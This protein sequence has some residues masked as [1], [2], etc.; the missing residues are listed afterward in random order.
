MVRSSSTSPTRTWPLREGAVRRDIGAPRRHRRP[1][2]DPSPVVIRTP[3]AAPAREHRVPRSVLLPQSKDE[4]LDDYRGADAFDAV[5]YPR[6][7]RDP[8]AGASSRGGPSRVLRGPVPP[9]AI[10]RPAAAG[11]LRPRHL[12]QT[13]IAD[14]RRT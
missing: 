5:L 6:G 14:P 9:R 12:D 10:G 2:F 1:L 7:S 3:R 13:E 4:T 11:R 8:R